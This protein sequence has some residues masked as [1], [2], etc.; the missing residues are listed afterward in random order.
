[1][2]VDEN[3][4]DRVDRLGLAYCRLNDW[5]WDEFI[6][7]KPDGF[8]KLPD[9]DPNDLKRICH[10]IL[11]QILAKLFPRRYAKVLAK[12]DYINPIMKRIQADI[13]DHARLGRDDV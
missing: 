2:D 3:V 12:D 11:M 7:P 9:Y 1:M 5:K 8:D 10:P 6:G 4:L 13:G